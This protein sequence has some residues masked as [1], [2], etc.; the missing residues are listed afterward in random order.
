MDL[1]DMAQELLTLDKN[2]PKFENTFRYIIYKLEHVNE[3]PEEI[4]KAGDY[5]RKLR[6][7][8]EG[9]KGINVYNVLQMFKVEYY[10]NTVRSNKEFIFRVNVNELFECR[11][12]IN[13]FTM[14]MGKTVPKGMYKPKNHYAVEYANILAKTFLAQ[15]KVKDESMWT[16]YVNLR[17]FVLSTFY[18]GLLDTSSIQNI[19]NIIKRMD[20]AILK[21]KRE[22]VTN[23]KSQ[24]SRMNLFGN[25]SFEN[26]EVYDE[27]IVVN[28]IVYKFLSNQKD[29]KDYMFE[30]YSIL[31]RLEQEGKLDSNTKHAKEMRIKTVYNNF[32]YS[33]DIQPYAPI[34]AFYYILR[35][36]RS[37]AE[38]MSYTEAELYEAC[39]FAKC[40]TDVL[41]DDCLTSIIVMNCTRL[42]RNDK[43]DYGVVL[44]ATYKANEYNF[45]YLV[46]AKIM[47]KNKAKTILEELYKEE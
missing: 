17:N 24:T 28:E 45:S 2:N 38:L 18:K 43:A 10:T 27:E 42:I 25:S 4:K 13:Q 46:N 3:S 40:F 26:L 36:K 7:K 11:N 39:K 9:T 15:Y 19:V 8:I 6:S 12:L 20:D 23:L 16:A 44:P 33:K 1:Y 34:E 14:I 21:Q 35:N 22:I 31:S 37:V 30:Q 32:I 29:I 5:L 41:S 47:D